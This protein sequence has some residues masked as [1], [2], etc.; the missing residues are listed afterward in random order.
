VCSAIWNERAG[1]AAFAVYAYADAARSYERAFRSTREHEQR[2]R[3]AERAAEAWYA[4]GD[5]E[6]SATWYA[7]AAE[8][9][10]QLGRRSHA[11]RLS[12][13]RARILSESGRYDEGLAEADRVA[14]DDESVDPALRFEAEVITAG[15]LVGQGRLL[16]ALER[17]QK[18]EKMSTTLDLSAT[19]AFSATYA[20]VLAFVG[21]PVEARSHFSA[22]LRNA[23]ASGDFDMILRTYNNWGSIE[24]IYGT[25]QR[26]S[27]L[28]GAGFPIAAQMK[29]LRQTAWLAQNAALAAILS[30]D[31]DGADDFLKQSSEIDHGVAV[32]QRWSLALRLR[33]ATLRALDDAD[34][35]S[36]ALHL[37]EDANAAHD[38][39]SLHVLAS[40]L[41]L[42]LAS[43]GAS[44]EA[45][46]VVAGATTDLERADAPY[47]IL[48]VACRFGDRALRAR[49]RTALTQIAAR[50]DAWPARGFAAMA[51]AREAQRQRDREG[52]N[53]HGSV[54]AAAFARAGWQ[55]E[56]AFALEIAGRVAEALATFRTAGALGE[57]RRLTETSTAPRRRGDSTLTSREREV[58]RLVV[59]GKTAKAIAEALVISERTVESHIASTYRKLGV[60]GR[61]A[62]AA[63]LDGTDG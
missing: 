11:G 13:R 49:A 20:C 5:V 6:S 23:Q 38:V 27:A 60:S 37:F 22:T 51:D 47:W 53:R 33:L 19:T 2:S 17:L 18:V 39:S 12:L 28:Y 36:R 48:D 15:L 10:R 61:V 34:L 3:V 43:H 63:L 35:V 58:A 59:A 25:V 16:E 46:R 30:G 21:K 62:L 7:H 41:A 54:A 44:D 9:N 32:V 56:E 31:L 4:I 8:V 55:L 24:M 14:G 57:V 1:D 29:N 26:A 42:H 40:V 50:T 45:A 52:A